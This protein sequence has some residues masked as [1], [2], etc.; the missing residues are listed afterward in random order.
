MSCTRTITLIWIFFPLIICY[1]ILCPL[2]NLITLY[3]RGILMKLHTFVK[4]IQTMCH[5]QEPYSCMFLFQI[6]PLETY[7]NAIFCP[8]YKLNT[9]KAIWL[10]LLKLLEH[11]E[12]MCHN[13]AL[14]IF[15]SYFPLIIFN[16]ISCPLY[17][18]ITVRGI[19]TKLH[20]F[21]KHIQTMCH[22]QEP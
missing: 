9:A 7:L 12:T 13:S 2:Y 15:W 14:D 21:V 3:N 6:I 22:A 4:H 16:A 1:A 19:S 5:A 11:N 17:N 8:L 20:T 18:L 10:K